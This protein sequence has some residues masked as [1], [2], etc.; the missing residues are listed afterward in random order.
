MPPLRLPKHLA[1]LACL[2][3]LSMTTVSEAAKRPC[4]PG[5][6][7]DPATGLCSPKRPPNTDR[8]R[9]DPQPPK[10]PKRTERQLPPGG[11]VMLMGTPSQRRPSP[12]PR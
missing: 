6:A 7:A 12:A 5:T 3:A 11:G 2:A 1:L 9:P 4:P 10:P 8:G